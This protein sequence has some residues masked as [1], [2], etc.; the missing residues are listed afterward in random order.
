MHAVTADRPAR[1]GVRPAPMVRGRAAARV[2]AAALALATALS[3]AA[4]LGRPA[5]AVVVA[6][7]GAALATG[8]TSLLQLP[9]PR[10]TTTV[11]ASSGALAAAAVGLTGNEPLLEW[12]APAL[13]AAVVGEF[14][15]Q[16][17]RS[18]GRPRMVESVCG[19]VAGVVVVGSL[20]SVVALPQSPVTAAGVLAWAVPVALA[21]AVLALPVPVRIAVPG[22][23]LV[24][25]VSG[26][27]LGGLL[28]PPTPLL[29]SARGL[30]NG[31]GS[32]ALLGPMA[33]AVAGAAA[34]AVAVMLYRLL[35]VLP[36]AGRT[37]G[38]LALAIAPLASSGM[39]GYVTLRLLAG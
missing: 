21:L 18:D 37:P 6:L 13:A 14:L 19:S 25:A 12:L 8:W 22:G 1:A 24:A 23:V 2:A 16:L 28:E 9:S 17:G 29:D 30:A 20:A 5:L 34:A 4:Y 7:A 31:P 39:V 38:W 33:G 35:A 26:A 3:A 11:V 27:L 32:S 36:R 15:H 10:G